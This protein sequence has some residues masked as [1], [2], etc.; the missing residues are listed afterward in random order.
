MVIARGLLKVRRQSIQP[1]IDHFGLSAGPPDDFRWHLLG[2]ALDIDGPITAEELRR[3]WSGEEFSVE[4]RARAH[5]LQAGP[6]E[7]R[8]VADARDA[9]SETLEAAGISKYQKPESFRRGEKGGDYKILWQLL[10][11]SRRR[12]SQRDGEIAGG[13]R[14]VRSR[15]AASQVATGVVGKVKGELGRLWGRPSTV[16]ALTAISNE[17]ALTIYQ[18]ADGHHDVA[19]S[20]RNEFLAEA[21]TRRL[22]E[23][24]DADEASAAG[25]EHLGT[26]LPGAQLG[27]ILRQLHSGDHGYGVEAEGVLYEH[28]NISVNQR[29]REGAL[30]RSVTYLAFT[31]KNLGRDIDVMSEARVSEMHKAARDRGRRYPKTMKGMSYAN[32]DGGSDQDRAVPLIEVQGHEDDDWA[33]SLVVGELDFEA[34]FLLGERGSP[35]RLDYLLEVLSSGSVLFV[36]SDLTES[37]LVSALARTADSKHHRYALVLAPGY[38]ELLGLDEEAQA[39][40]RW[41]LAQRYLHLGVAPVIVDLPYEITQALREI[42]LEAEH[43]DAYDDYD[44]RLQRWTERLDGHGGIEVNPDGLSIKAKESRKEW[45]AALERA[46][47]NVGGDPGTEPLDVELWLLDGR[48]ETL[49]RVASTD[50]RRNFQTAAELFAESST[51]HTSKALARDAYQR[52][53]PV[54]ADLR[55]GKLRFG[56]AHNIVIYGKKGERLPVGVLAILS[57]N[58]DGRLRRFAADR[59]SRG[60]RENKQADQIKRLLPSL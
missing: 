28:L 3:S 52:G 16:A 54:E 27:S 50:A 6:L 21:I 14:A 32:P 20:G 45:K 48:D 18:G 49:H 8:N 23:R 59:T 57:G 42:A 60:L 10:E 22:R 9:A 26:S 19:A 31:M 36:G 4:A 53:H 55:D 2:V 29:K 24:Q 17:R 37:A 7:Y 25:L 58:A 39:A 30:A 34:D 46:I 11:L 40:S 1:L 13:P 38:G 47:D 15:G 44:V 41:L 12:G 51:D 56:I 5:L 33:Q 43:G 35:S